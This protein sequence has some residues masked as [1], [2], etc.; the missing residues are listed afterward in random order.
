M[1]QSPPIEQAHK[2]VYKILLDIILV[3]QRNEGMDSVL[4][5]TEF[6]VA[7]EKVQVC[8]MSS[9]DVAALMPLLMFFAVLL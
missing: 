5:P 2:Q 8:T 3:H 9:E 1:P 6:R 4:D 7:C